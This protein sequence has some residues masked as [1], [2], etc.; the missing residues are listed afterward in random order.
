[1]CQQG[2]CNLVLRQGDWFGLVENVPSGIDVP[3]GSDGASGA[4]L[5]GRHAL[6]WTGEACIIGVSDDSTQS[7]AAG[8][9]ELPE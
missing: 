5:N 4:V 9:G 8:E 3:G 2:Y 7:I 1:V 6:P